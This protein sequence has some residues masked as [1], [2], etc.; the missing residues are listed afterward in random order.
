MHFPSAESDPG[1][2]AS[3]LVA[4]VKSLDPE[5]W[6]KLASGYGP[7]VYGWARRAG[8]GR[9]DA[10][11]ITQEVFRAVAAWADRL[12]HGRPGDTF[13]GWL[14]TI[15]QNKIRD[16]WRRTAGRLQAAGGSDAHE[17]LMSFPEPDPSS[18]DAG[19]FGDRMRRVVD[20][21]RCEFEDRTW[22]AFWR[23][24][25]DDR[26]V[27]EVGRELDMTANAVYVARSRVLRRLR[28][29]LDE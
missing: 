1:S 26:P 5:A 3:S 20:S 17:R 24:T 15:T 16:L 8:L 11:D 28:E 9:E 14:R 29:M 12:A 13:R 21:V 23:V 19:I 4:G 10:A 7:L 6:R 18:S 25:V 27:A 22:Q 2:T